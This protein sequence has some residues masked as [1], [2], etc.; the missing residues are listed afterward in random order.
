MQIHVVTLD[1]DRAQAQLDPGVRELAAVHHQVR[2]PAGRNRG[3]LEQ[4]VGDFPSVPGAPSL[5]APLQDRPIG[6]RL[7]LGE[8]LRLDGG[9]AGHGRLYQGR[10]AADVGTGAEH[11]V[12]VSVAWPVARTGPSAPELDLVDY[13]AQ[14]REPE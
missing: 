5:G 8:R 1:R 14:V 12:P 13:V 3:R 9:V 11:E 4:Q 2:N 6:P 10:R 7:D